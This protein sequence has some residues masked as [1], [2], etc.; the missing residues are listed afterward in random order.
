MER[1]GGRSPEERAAAR[2]SRDRA[3]DAREQGI[4]LEDEEQYEDERDDVRG[5]R[6]PDIGSMSRYGGGMDVYTRR[7]VIAVAGAIGVILVLFLMLG[8]C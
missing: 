6:D 1:S 4:P 3:R 5:W 8:G 7:R 2:E